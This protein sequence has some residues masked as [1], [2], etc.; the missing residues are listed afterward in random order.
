MILGC[1]TAN[2]IVS[3]KHETKVMTFGSLFCGLSLAIANQIRT[4]VT[5]YILHLKHHGGD[6]NKA[7]KIP[8]LPQP[9]FP[10]VI[11][12]FTIYFHQNVCTAKIL[13]GIK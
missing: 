10:I 12:C 13:N 3:T 11:R 6:N 9:L 8:F 4:R 1:Q 5:P 7:T 2:R